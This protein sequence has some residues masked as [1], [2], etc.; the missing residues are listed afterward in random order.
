MKTHCKAIKLGPPRLSQSHTD[1][2]HDS[3][4]NT[5]IHKPKQ[6]GQIAESIRRFGFTNPILIDGANNV[7]AGHGRLAAAKLLGLRVVSTICISHLSPAEQRAYM[8]ADNRLGDLSSFDR[9]RLAIEVSLI[10]E[11]EPDFDLGI[12]GF[13]EDEIELLLDGDV[14]STVREQPAP[15]PE[16]SRPALTRLGDVWTLGRH[17]L[18]CGT[19]LERDSYLTL[20]GRERAWMVFS[21]APVRRQHR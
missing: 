2:L 11:D 16:R 9:K 17:K 4:N 7:L 8:I 19:A 3:P 6:I 20:M 1:S 15:P 13:D 12:T 10:L 21:D 18:L 14:S 5:R